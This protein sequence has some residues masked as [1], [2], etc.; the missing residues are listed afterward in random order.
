MEIRQDQYSTQGTAGKAVRYREGTAR[1]SSETIFSGVH[2]DSLAARGPG[3][4]HWLAHLQ[5][6]LKN[7]VQAGPPRA[8]LRD[9]HAQKIKIN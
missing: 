3:A 2:K 9:S 8:N 7:L 5:S 4:R 6:V 1:T